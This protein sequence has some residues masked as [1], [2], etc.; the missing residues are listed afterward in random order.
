MK[1]IKDEIYRE[2]YT[3]SQLALLDKSIVNEIKLEVHTAYKELNK[4]KVLNK[5]NV[6]DNSYHL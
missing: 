4:V 1:D 3:A 2:L 6:Q 5:E